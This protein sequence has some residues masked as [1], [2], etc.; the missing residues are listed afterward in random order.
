MPLI[1]SFLEN[2]LDIPFRQT[3]AAHKTAPTFLHAPLPIPLCVL[4]ALCG[5]PPH[6]DSENIPHRITL[7][8]DPDPDPDPDFDFDFDFFS[9]GDLRIKL[10]A[11]G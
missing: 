4:C 10:P 2:F 7:P 9:C 6:P 8:F 11:D 3:K 5:S 1:P